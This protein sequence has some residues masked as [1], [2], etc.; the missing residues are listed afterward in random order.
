MKKKILSLF[1]AFAVLLGFA[2]IVPANAETA[3]IAIDLLAGIENADYNF[4]QIDSALSYGGGENL[5]CFKIAD[6]GTYYVGKENGGGSLKIRSNTVLDLNGSTLIRSGETIN[7]LQNCDAYGERSEGGYNLSKNITIKNG[8]IDGIGG[9]TESANLV[10]IGHADGVILENV[11]F[12]N[13]RNGHLVEFSG[14]KDV[15]VSGC[16]FSGLLAG[17]GAAEDEGMEAL[18][19]DIARKGW[20]GAFNGDLTVCRDI[21]VSD[22]T[23][24]DYPSGVGNHHTLKGNHSSNIVIKNNKFLNS[25]KSDLPAV[26]CYGFDNS[27][28]SD[29]IISGNYKN[30]VTVSGGNVAVL[31]NQIKNCKE[32]A[33]YFTRSSSHLGNENKRQNEST[34]GG[35][36]INNAITA[37]NGK[38]GVAVYSGSVLTDIYK[39]NISSVKTALDISGSDTSVKNITD[40]KLKSTGGNGIRISAARISAINKNQVNSSDTA[41][42]LSSKANASII[43]AK[44][45]GNTLVSTKN[46]GV[47]LTGSCVNTKLEYNKITAKSGMGVSVAKSSK[48]TGTLYGNDIYSK[49]AAVSVTSGG[50]IN[51][52]RNSKLISTADN[53]ISVSGSK[54][55]SV[56]Q[57]TV[58]S[59]KNNGLFMSKSTVGTIDKNKFNISRNSAINIVSSSKVNDIKNNSIQKFGKSGIYISSSSS[60]KNITSNTV[61]SGNGNG[62]YITSSTVSGKIIKNTIE[63]CKKNGS[64]IYVTSTGKFK[65][66]QSNKI[67][68]CTGYGIY[69]CNKKNKSVNVT[70]NKLSKNK[71]GAI[72]VKAK[73]KV[74]KK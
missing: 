2:G 6:D 12:K 67:S 5:L 43:G 17:D 48:I 20:N 49:K 54:V 27:I 57:N 26:W 10:N 66:V 24:S 60:V 25:K 51:Q 23:F 1:L 18:Q 40:N 28:V 29:N 72:Y 14:C 69:N 42:Q 41:L 65:T 68:K 74:Q 59:K 15:T 53:A 8:T 58:E 44:K 37:T 50:Y 7:F 32:E 4:S 63:N 35:K 13:C 22:C 33:I 19:L 61:K 31:N 73:G 38:V 62:I 30:G 45:A 11:N 46:S 70:K 34:T 55:N 56:Y 36:I 21:T 3:T 39:N 16:T 47:I 9:S 52:L 64:G 71:K